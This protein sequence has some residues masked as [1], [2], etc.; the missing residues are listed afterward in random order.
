MQLYEIELSG[1]GADG[2]WY[3]HTAVVQCED[4]VPAGVCPR[5]VSSYGRLLRDIAGGE[6]GYQVCAHWPTKVAEGCLSEHAVS[7]G[8]L[9]QDVR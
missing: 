8:P 2:E 7:I 9:M 3:F 1:T 5:A 6:V 4:E